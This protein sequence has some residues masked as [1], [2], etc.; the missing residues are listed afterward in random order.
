MKLDNRRA[1]SDVKDE[2]HCF[3]STPNSP[4][5]FLLVHPIST[6]EVHLYEYFEHPGNQSN[7][8]PKRNLLFVDVNPKTNYSEYYIA[9]TQGL[10]RKTSKI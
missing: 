6:E 3:P 8:V 7:I 2:K 4:E 1:C 5:S 10:Q 9:G